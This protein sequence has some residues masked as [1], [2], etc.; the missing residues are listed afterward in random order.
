MKKTILFLTMA[1][2]TFLGAKAQTWTASEVGAGDFYLYNVGAG[3]FLN[4]GNSW[5]TQASLNYVGIETTL[6]AT[7]DYYFSET[8]K[9]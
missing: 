9:C 5:G 3:K 2:I 4:G 6:T 8:T 7:G 1:F